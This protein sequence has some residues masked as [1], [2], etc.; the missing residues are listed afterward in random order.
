MHSIGS[1]TC[2]IPTDEALDAMKDLTSGAY[3]LLI[4]YYSKS[5]GWKFEDSQIAD[6]MGVSVK[7]V[8]DLKRELIAKNYLW[9]EKG[10]SLD[11][12][13]IGRRAV[14]AWKNPDVVSDN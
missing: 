12:Y 4:Y 10:R 9:I 3:K 5:T 11:N 13:F 2:R 8:G 6:T 7:T 14:A 1:H